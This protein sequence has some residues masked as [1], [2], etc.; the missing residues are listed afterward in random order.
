VLR[1]INMLRFWFAIG[2]ALMA[3]EAGPR[4]AAEEPAEPVEVAV[5]THPHSRA[6]V[7]AAARLQLAIAEGR[8]GDVHDLATWLATHPMPEQ[9]GWRP[10]LDELD[11]AARNIQR[12]NDLS[13]AGVELGRLGHACGGCHQAAGVSIPSSTKPAPS[14]TATLAAQMKRQQWAS[15]RMWEGLTGSD[16]AWTDGANV[17]ADTRVDVSGEMRDKPSV[18][19]FE[20]TE[21][22]RDQATHALALRELDARANHYGEVIQTCAGCH[23]I[24]RPSPVVDPQRPF[25]SS[26]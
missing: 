6:P 17:M 7:E 8:L 11:S 18:E 1:L 20:L 26:R 25:V 21:R 5:A 22:L 15:A 16:R 4:F 19:A 12:A 3:C 9:P 2:S 24:L 13:S 14:N 10:Y 23:Q